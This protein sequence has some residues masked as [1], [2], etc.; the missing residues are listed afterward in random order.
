MSGKNPDYVQMDALVA[1]KIIKHCQEAEGT[2]NS[3]L[4]QGVLLGL[5]ESDSKCLEVTN[6]FPH[7][8]HNDDDESFDEAIYQVEMMR[9]LRHVNIDHLHVGWYQ[10]SYFGMYFNRA[11]LDSQY[12]YQNSIKES[13]VIIYDPLRTSKGHLALKALRLSPMMMDLYKENIFTADKMAES[14]INFENIYE[15]VP[16]VVKNSHLM[17]ALCCEMEDRNEEN[18]SFPF[19]DLATGPVL[20]KI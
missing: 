5:V 16:I 10:S 17:N 4:V 1:L 6:C 20:E 18:N 11:L 3:S 15:E 14:K 13:I 8:K 19:L 12:S 7:P 9:K 2:G